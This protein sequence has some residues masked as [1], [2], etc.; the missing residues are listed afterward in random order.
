MLLEPVQPD[1]DDND[2]D[3]AEVCQDGDKVNIQLLIRV[4]VLDVL[5]A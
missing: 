3:E 4:E 5:S 2:V 1:D